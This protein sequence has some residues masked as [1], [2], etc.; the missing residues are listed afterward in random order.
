[1]SS[2]KIKL[3]DSHPLC[4]PSYSKHN[5]VEH[6]AQD[7]RG[8]KRFGSINRSHEKRLKDFQKLKYR[9]KY[10]RGKTMKITIKTITEIQTAYSPE[11]DIT[12]ILKEITSVEGDLISTEVVGFYYGAPN[13]QDTRDYLGHLKAE[14]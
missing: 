8:G 14:Y 7:C 5:R 3:L 10:L 4:A 12:F 9:K 13:E 11:T 2:E 6:T 1:M